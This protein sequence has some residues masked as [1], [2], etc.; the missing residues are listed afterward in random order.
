M[1]LSE[2]RKLGGIVAR[3][4][5]YVNLMRHLKD[6]RFMFGYLLQR[7]YTLL[8]L[9]EQLAEGVKFINIQKTHFCS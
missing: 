4:V 9:R 1:W 7:T 6:V 3:D 8:L 2:S 5:R